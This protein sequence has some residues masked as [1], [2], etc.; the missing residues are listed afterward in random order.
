MHDHP[1]SL[2]ALS[3]VSGSPTEWR[4]AGSG[5]CTAGACSRHAYS[6]PLTAMSYYIVDAGVL[7]RTHS[8]LTTSE[9]L[10]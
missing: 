8:V 5:G 9:V 1:G 2:G 6:P 7:R 4:W 3:V 10:A